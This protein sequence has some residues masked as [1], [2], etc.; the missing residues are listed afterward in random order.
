[1]TINADKS[2]EYEYVEG[3]LHINSKGKWKIVSDGIQ[4]NSDLKLDSIFVKEAFQKLYEGKLFICV[5]NFEGHNI[6]EKIIFNGNKDDYIFIKPS[7]NDLLHKDSLKSFTLTK[8]ILS[9]TINIHYKIKNPM[10]N[11][12]EVY[13]IDEIL[14]HNYRFFRN[15]VWKVRGR[16]LVDNEKGNMMF[17]TK[18][19]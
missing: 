6:Y 4:F 5:K 16:K 13:T 11:V 19:K 18:R 10:S 9:D 1:M 3:L 8:H 12:F 7:C 17:F 2:Y 15:K 14:H